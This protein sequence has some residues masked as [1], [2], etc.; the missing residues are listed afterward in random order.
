M[1]SIQGLPW[2]FCGADLVL[3]IPSVFA[4]G[5]AEDFASCSVALLNGLGGS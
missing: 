3:E 1:I 2:R 5:S 4:S